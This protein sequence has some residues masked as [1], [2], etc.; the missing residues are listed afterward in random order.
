MGKS[1]ICVMK[2]MVK[3]QIIIHFIIIIVELISQNHFSLCLN[4]FN[5]HFVNNRVVKWKIHNHDVKKTKI[6]LMI[7]C[8]HIEILLKEICDGER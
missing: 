5:K 2:I 8:N 4:I 6:N 3:W 7:H 1:Y